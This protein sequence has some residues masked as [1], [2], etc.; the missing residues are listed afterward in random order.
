M[1]DPLIAVRA[2]HLAAT[3]AA[4]GAIFFRLWVAAPAMRDAGADPALRARLDAELARIA[5]GSLALVVLSPAGWLM[6]VA[7]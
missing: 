6:L 4:G 3:A 7:G 2:V 1:I 5:S